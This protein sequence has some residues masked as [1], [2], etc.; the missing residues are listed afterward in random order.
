[1]ARICHTNNCPVGVTTQR[2]EL[3]K[4][5]PGTPQNVVTFFQV[6]SSSDVSL[7]TS[8]TCTPIGF[9]CL[10]VYI[11]H[12]KTSPLCSNVHV[13]S[14]SYNTGM[15]NHAAFYFSPETHMT[16]THVRHWPLASLASPR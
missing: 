2:E 12:R 8:D 10:I 16:L 1:M 14:L 4:K 13:V 11:R 5:F 15:V 6:M 9:H 3:R 7:P